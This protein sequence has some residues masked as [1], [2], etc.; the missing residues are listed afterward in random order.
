MRT[1]HAARDI[2][3]AHSAQ[4]RGGRVLIRTMENLTGRMGLIK[5]AAG[6]VQDIASG[7][8]LWDV[9]VTR[10]GLSLEVVQG[11]L[12]HIPKDRPVIVIANHPYGIL[13]GLMMGH[14]LSQTRGTFKILANDVFC[15]SQDVSDVILP[16]RFDP[17]K[18]AL[19]Q[20]LATRRL[21][22]DHL[23]QGGAI[24]LFPGGAV[25][26]SAH[27]FSRPMDPG[28]GPFTARMVAK[29]QAVV[30]PVFFEGQC[31]RLFQVAS[32]LHM[33]LRLGLLIREF[34]ARVDTPVRVHVGPVMGRDQLDPLAGDA[35]SLMAFLRAK[36]YE[37]SPTPIDPSSVGYEW[38]EQRRRA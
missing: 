7:Q 25:S 11:Q 15:R 10:Y 1:S 9:M 18:A 28:W 20:N 35:K 2:S 36:T 23:G 17:T 12:S 27:P 26:T 38:N 6:Y 29:S 5:R 33:T 19:E 4:T 8:D 14:I 34:R 24:G 37:L 3:Y 32:H 31:S 22:L 21:A 16:V 30:V 13:D